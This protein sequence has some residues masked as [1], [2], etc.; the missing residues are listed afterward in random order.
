MMCAGS[1]RPPPEKRTPVVGEKSY[2]GKIMI[3]AKIILKVLGS[4][5]FLEVLLLSGCLGLGL[6]YGEH[7]YL[8]FGVPVLCALFLG[9]TFKMFAAMP[10]TV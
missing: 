10:K 4:L 7:D 6:F 1:E 5:L 3:N 9:I 2:Y 8:S